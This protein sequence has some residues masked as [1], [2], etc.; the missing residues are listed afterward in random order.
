V[1]HGVDDGPKTDSACPALDARLAG[2]MASEVGAIVGEETGRDPEIAAF[3]ALARK[4]LE[5][6]VQ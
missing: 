3:E 4:Y 2:E 5:L 6:P 1:V